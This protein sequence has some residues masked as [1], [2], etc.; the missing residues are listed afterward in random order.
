MINIRI[1]FNP[2]EYKRISRQLPF[3]IHISNPQG[4]VLSTTQ[5]TVAM[6]TIDPPKELPDGMGYIEFVK[7]AYEVK[8]N[9]SHIKLRIRRCGSFG[10]EKKSEIFTRDNTAEEGTHYFCA[11]NNGGLVRFGPTEFYKGLQHILITN[12]QKLLR[13][14]DSYRTTK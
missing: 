13:H 12:L 5:P 8:A 2:N 9:Q 7:P 14:V 10:R 4:C 11:G 1:D 6:F 3:R